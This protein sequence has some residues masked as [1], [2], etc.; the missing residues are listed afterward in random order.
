MQ[1]QDMRNSDKT[2]NM[3]LVLTISGLLYGFTLLVAA[4]FLAVWGE[5]TY[6]P[7]RIYVSPLGDLDPVFMLLC[8]CFWG[9]LFALSAVK[10]RLLNMLFWV[11]MAFHYGGVA[12]Y[13]HRGKMPG[14][15]S[16]HTVLNWG[17]GLKW[18][19]YTSVVIYVL[20][21]IFLISQAI[22][23]QCREDSSRQA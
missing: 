9:G 1:Q 19:F 18:V 13:I 10:Q 2:A 22:R 7:I 3:V 8:P 16:V 23:I 11:V 4:M 14:E 5:G 17:V 12:Y 20:G 15:R 21:Q 6:L